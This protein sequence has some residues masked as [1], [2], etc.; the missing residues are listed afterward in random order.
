MASPALVARAAGWT[1]E[2]AARYQVALLRG[3]AADRPAQRLYLRKVQIVEMM[4]TKNHGGKQEGTLLEANTKNLDKA[5]AVA[6][7]RSSSSSGQPT[8]A[9]AKSRGRRRKSEAQH[10]KSVEKL[11]HKKLQ[12]R[13]EAAAAKVGGSPPNVLARVIACCGRFWQLL[14][15]EG[16]EM[17]ERLRAAEAAKSKAAA[18]DSA[19]LN[20]MRA[21]MAATMSPAM[22]V[23]MDEDRALPLKPQAH[24]PVKVERRGLLAGR[25]QQPERM[26]PFVF[27]QSATPGASSGGGGAAGK[28]D[29]KKTY[30]ASLLRRP[31]DGEAVVGE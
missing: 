6:G 15:P 1:P 7:G 18:K 19:G 5:A 12:S 8:G 10:R 17:M 21:A 16:A 24:D 28:L 2:E 13:C 4:R 14:H 22:F 9:A 11:Q 27:G 3:L 23:P 30:A 29:S 20:A 25:K 26:E 31:P